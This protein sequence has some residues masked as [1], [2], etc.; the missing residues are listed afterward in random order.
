MTVAVENEHITSANS[1]A[2]IDGGAE[3]IDGTIMGFGAG[4]G[5]AQLELV[6]AILEKRGIDT[7]ANLNKMLDVAETVVSTFSDVYQGILP[8]N[9]ISGVAGVFSSYAPHVK[10]AAEQF[11]LDGRELF[12]ELGKRGLVGGQEDVIVEVAALMANNKGGK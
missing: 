6:Q 1:L 8:I 7:G 3:I 4:A 5:N 11:R 9:V 2:A 12:V 10:E